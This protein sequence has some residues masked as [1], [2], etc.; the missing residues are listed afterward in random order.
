LVKVPYLSLC[1]LIF[2]DET[3]PENFCPA[4]KKAMDYQ[5]KEPESANLDEYRLQISLEMMSPFTGEDVFVN[6][7]RTSKLPQ[8][9]KKTPARQLPATASSPKS[10]FCVECLDGTQD[11]RHDT[12]TYETAMDILTEVGIQS[13]SIVEIIGP[14]ES[15]DIIFKS[16]NKFGCYEGKTSNFWLLGYGLSEEDMWTCYGE[17]GRNVPLLRDWVFEE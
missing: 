6:D 17:G 8:S 12:T 13:V 15:F 2:S 11:S 1:L 16:G 7:A 10:K 3:P 14:V 5:A 4:M 9:P